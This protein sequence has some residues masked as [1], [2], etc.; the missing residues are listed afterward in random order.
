MDSEKL[1]NIR[2]ANG[3]G[4]SGGHSPSVPV[5][6]DSFAPAHLAPAGLPTAVSRAA[7]QPPGFGKNSGSPATSASDTSVI[8]LI[9]NL[10]DSDKL[11][12]ASKCDEL[13]R[14][15]QK[16][17]KMCIVMSLLSG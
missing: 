9:G 17:L 1:R 14:N 16:Y 7:A 8:D 15:A 6:F 5:K 10:G 3:P 2:E 4:A 12:G 11:L 13:S